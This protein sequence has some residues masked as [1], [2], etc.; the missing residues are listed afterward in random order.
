MMRNHTVAGPLE[1]AR[2]RVEG[3][4]GHAMPWSAELSR[5]SLLIR[6]DKMHIVAA[7]WQKAEV[8]AF[9]SVLRAAGLV[10]PPRSVEAAVNDHAG[11]SP[12]GIHIA[13]GLVQRKDSGV[14]G[15]GAG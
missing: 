11:P 10:I 5:W 6:V 3:I 12:E 7:S 13:T 2:A 1:A 9:E 8:R 14:P 4:L 15:G